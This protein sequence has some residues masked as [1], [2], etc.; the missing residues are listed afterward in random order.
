MISLAEQPA[1]ASRRQAALRRPCALVPLASP[2]A[3]QHSR[4]HVLKP[5]AVRALPNA[6]AE[7]R[8]FAVNIWQRFQMPAPV[9]S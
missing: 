1:S 5:L 2:A 7:A 8:Q 4:N 6:V 3:L 9:P